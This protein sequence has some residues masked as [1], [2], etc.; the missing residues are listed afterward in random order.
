[1]FNLQ[2]GID[3]IRILPSQEDEEGPAIELPDLFQEPIQMIRRGR[4]ILKIFRNCLRD[5]RECA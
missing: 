2:T 1:M 4:G 3:R 5:R